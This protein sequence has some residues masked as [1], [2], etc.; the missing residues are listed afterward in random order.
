MPEPKAWEISAGLLPIGRLRGE[1][2]AASMAGTSTVRLAALLTQRRKSPSDSTP[3]RWPW[4][5]TRKMTR[6]WL[7]VIF[8]RARRT[9]SPE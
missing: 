2:L 8:S 6:A 5:S 7:A 3:S 1:V 9:G 4:E